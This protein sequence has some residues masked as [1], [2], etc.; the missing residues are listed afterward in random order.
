VIDQQALAEMRKKIDDARQVEEEILG[1]DTANDSPDDS[2]ITPRFVAECF[3]LNERGDG[4][5]FAAVHKNRL[6]YVKKFTTWL[7]WAGNHWKL[8]E[9]DRYVNAVEEVAQYYESYAANLKDRIDELRR[10]D[11][12]AEAKILTALV[13]KYKHRINKLRSLKGARTCGDYAHRLGDQSLSIIG[14]E[15]DQKPMLLACPNAVVNLATGEVVESLPDDYILNAVT[16]EWKGINE[17]CPEWE[18]FFATIHLDDEEIMR[19]VHAMLGYSTTGLRTEHFIGCFIGEGRNGK[20]T[21]FETLRSILGDLGWTISPELLLEQKFNRSSA[22][23]SPDLFSLMGRRMVIASETD[24]NARISASQVKRLTGG[25]T[26]KTRA[27]HDKHEINFKPSHKLFLYT[28]HAPQGLAKDYALYK[29]LLFIDYPLKFVEN[30]KEADERQRDANLPAKLEAEASGILAW[31]VRGAL[32]WK[33]EGGLKPPAKVQARIDEIRLADDSILQF[34]TDVLQPADEDIS[35]KFADV[36]TK[37]KEWYVGDNGPGEEKMKWLPSKVKLSK[38]F[39]A[40]GHKID[41][42][43]G[44]ATIYGIDFLPIG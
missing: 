43:G 28:N 20:G 44:K 8:D 17:P 33:A 16:T 32:I 30:P 39:T 24:E 42:P 41:K 4:L 2:G 12:N 15:L 38:W 31:L 14:E 22:G 25:D 9:E 34:F 27:P 10:T 6:V 40:K 26:I 3:R 5:L 7:Y 23:P 37:F 29:R 11:H 13:T 1:L 36:Y 19:L 21:M 18:K 35:L